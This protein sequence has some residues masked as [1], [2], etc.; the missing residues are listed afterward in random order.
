[1]GCWTGQRVKQSLMTIKSE[2]YLDHFCQL[3]KQSL[4]LITIKSELL[5]YYVHCSSFEPIS[6]IKIVF[7]SF[8]I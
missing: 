7:L 5:F 6:Y 3:F 8:Q 4:I 2:L 1:M